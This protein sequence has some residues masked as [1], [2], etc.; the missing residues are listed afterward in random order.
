M[1]ILPIPSLVQIEQREHNHYKPTSHFL[2]ELFETFP[3]LIWNDECITMV[4][5]VRIYDKVLSYNLFGVSKKNNH[6]LL[7]CP[8]SIKR[9]I[10][11]QQ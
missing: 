1:N 11:L 5:M 2:Y 7:T 8:N 4:N 3:S 6:N 10:Y 9:V